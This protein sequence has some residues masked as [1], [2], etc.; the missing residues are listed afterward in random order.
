VAPGLSPRALGGLE[1]P[2]GLFARLGSR[3]VLLVVALCV[4]LP[5]HHPLLLWGENPAR[6]DPVAPAVALNLPN[7]VLGA[8]GLVL[9]GRLVTR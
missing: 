4:A 7:L 6:L 5:V 1:V 9:V 8:A 2:V 3:S